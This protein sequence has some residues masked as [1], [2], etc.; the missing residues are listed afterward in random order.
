MVVPWFEIFLILILIIING[1]FSCAEI[2]VIASRKTY[3]QKLSNQG[4]KRAKRIEG[5]QKNPERFLATIQIGITVVG[6]SAAAIGGVTA[7]Q[8]VQPLLELI[9]IKIIQ[10]GSEAIAIAFVVAIIS[11][12]TLILGELV[13]K[14]I[15][16]R[17]PDSIALWVG[18]PV[19]R[20]AQIAS[21]FIKV[22]TFSSRLI[23]KPFGVEGIQKS[24]FVSKEEIKSL[25][26]EGRETGVF[27]PTEQEL[28]HSVFEFADISVK[29]VMVPRPKIHAFP[30]NSPLEEVLNYIDENRF[31]RYPVYD[32]GLNDIKGILYYKDLMGH[33][34]RK[35]PVNIVDILH[36]PYFVPET[37]KVS[38]LLK[39]LQRRR[40]QIAIVINEYGSVEGLVTM[41]D[42]IEEIVG[43]IQDEYDI[44]EKPVEQLKDGSFLVDASLSIRDLK[45]DY[46]LVFPESPDYETLGGFIFSQLQN[47]PRSGE[48]IRCNK[49]KITIIH[50]EGRRIA[51]VK[52]EKDLKAAPIEKASSPS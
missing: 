28:I 26:K 6:A 8:V 37:M 22:L 36:S 21:P 4:D 15:A 7:V 46:G 38:H 5:L 34:V 30:L 2:A 19:E 16:L 29:E 52:M 23:L 49:F 3:I 47:I 20:L 10:G 33:L 44:E 25:L 42:L 24:P 35:E 51:K 1:L 32:E 13:P 11:Y 45:D 48:I 27:D 39:E 43:E 31:A 17:N 40:L 9:P 41:E 18:H 14:S 12:L 50:V